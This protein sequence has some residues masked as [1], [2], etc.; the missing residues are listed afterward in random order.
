MTITL[1]NLLSYEFSYVRENILGYRL[2]IPKVAFTEPR[3]PRNAL[4]GVPALFC[5]IFEHFALLL[6]PV[7]EFLELRSALHL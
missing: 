4:P 1:N 7:P 6:D 5:R 2:L 3:K